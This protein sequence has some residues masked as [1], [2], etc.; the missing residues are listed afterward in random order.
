MKQ[1]EISKLIERFD[2]IIEM[3]PLDR[4][5][6]V[7]H[8]IAQIG[9]RFFTSPASGSEHKHDAEPGGLLNHSLAVYDNLK[10]LQGM[11]FPNIPTDSV[12]IAGLFHDLGKIGTFD[13]DLISDSG[14]V[15]GLDHYVPSIEDWQKRKGILYT[16]NKSI[17]DGLSHA[18]RSAR[19]L[20]Q[21]GVELTDNEYLSIVY[22]DGLY[23]KENALLVSIHGNELLMALHW[24]DYYTAFFGTERT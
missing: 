18:Q 19:L 17:K 20:S 4:H 2:K 7:E 5:A 21:C 14:S 22:H 23:M 11:W 12:I 13:A 15:G 6:Q 16:W 10:M 1:E 8:M 24:A 3:L 9:S